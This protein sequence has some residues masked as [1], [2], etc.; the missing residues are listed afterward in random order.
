MGDRLNIGVIGVGKAGEQLINASMNHSELKV[1]GIYDKDTERLLQV[2]R[3]YWLDSYSSYEKMLE[4]DDIDIIYLATPPKSHY[5]LSVDIF[6]SHKHFIC[7]RPLATTMKH[8]EKMTSL[9]ENKDRI[10][11]INFPMIYESTYKK[12]KQLLDEDYIGRLLRIEVQAYLPEWPRIGQENSWIGSREQGGFTREVMIHY[13]QAA[14][15]LF[16]DIENINS[17]IDYPSDPELSEKSLVANGNI[18]GAKIIFNCIS[19]VGIK[20]DIKFNIIGSKGAISFKNWN[21]LWL[22][23]K[24]HK[25]RKPKL[26]RIDTLSILLDNIYRGIVGEDFDIVDF[27]EGAKTHYVIEKLLGN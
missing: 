13:I 17:Y 19:D 22:Y 21:E 25:I 1:K 23:K 24:G 18:D 27:K 11:A 14:Q 9:A 4:D 26:E 8:I 7:E 2:S 5:S 10:Y 6:K 20:E 12:I 16:G 15:R 3:T